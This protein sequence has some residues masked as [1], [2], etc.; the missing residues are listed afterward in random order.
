M[1]ARYIAATNNL[2]FASEALEAAVT[3]ARGQGLL[4]I[5]FPTLAWMSCPE[6]LTRARRGG[7]T[8]TLRRGKTGALFGVGTVRWSGMVKARIPGERQQRTTKQDVLEKLRGSLAIL[9]RR[10]LPKKG[11][12]E[13]SAVAHICLVP[14]TDQRQTLV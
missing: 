8:E 2:N 7:S 4:Q 13:A 14:G 5:R 1:K 10:D 9:P 6:V 11:K 12:F 3:P